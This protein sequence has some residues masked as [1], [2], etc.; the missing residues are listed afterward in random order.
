MNDFFILLL[1]LIFTNWVICVAH[2][3]F[4]VDQ[5]YSVWFP[6]A[7]IIPYHIV[8]L[9]FC[10]KMLLD[11]QTSVTLSPFGRGYETMA[12]GTKKRQTGGSYVYWG[13]PETPPTDPQ[14]IRKS[15]RR[16]RSNCIYIFFPV[17]QHLNKPRISATGLLCSCL[18]APPL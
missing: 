6:G 5:R 16:P 2:G 10:T 9:L 7:H 11:P 15:G 8:A 13:M 14:F 12:Q 4:G 1:F 3:V 17:L 18:V